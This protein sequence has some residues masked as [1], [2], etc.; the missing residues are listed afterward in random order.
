MSRRQREGGRRE[1]EEEGR[2]EKAL[3]KKEVRTEDRCMESV[4]KMN[5]L[6]GLKK[7][8]RSSFSSR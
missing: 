6:V 2:V 4:K 5:Q 7:D 8:M 3:M 1:F